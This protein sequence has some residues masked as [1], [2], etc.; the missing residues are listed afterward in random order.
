MTTV[1]NPAD[2]S[3]A[4]E[5]ADFDATQVEEVAARLRAA[6]VDWERIGPKGRAEWMG[7]YRDWLLD[8]AQELADQLQ[9]EAGKIRSEAHIE[10]ALALQVLNYYRENAARFL[11]T[12]HPGPHGLAGVVKRQWVHH[13][14]QPLIGVITPWNFPVALALWDA[15][16]ALMA[17][18]AVIVKPSEITPLA[19]R[20]VIEGWK[21]IGAPAI[22]E[23]VTGGAE[24][25]QAVV[26]T[27]DLIQFTGSTRTGRRIAEQAARRLIP[28]EL[29]LGGKDAAVVL[30]DA[31]VDQAVNA[32][33]WGALFNSGQTCVSVERVYV[34]APVYD[35]FLAKLVAKVGELRDA[36]QGDIGAMATEAQ[37]NLVADQVAD[38]E[39]KGARIL[40]GGKQVGQPGLYF[41]PTVLSQVDHTMTCMTE[42]TFGPL[43]PVMRVSDVDDAVARVNDSRYGLSAAIFSGSARRAR[44][45]AQRLEVGAVNVND[46]ILNLLAFS[47]P[48]GGWKESGIGSR[49]GGA[50][51]ILKYCRKQAIVDNLLPAPLPLMR[52]PYQWLQIDLLPR[53][54]RTLGARGILRRL[55]AFR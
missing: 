30:A 12:E 23:C 46:V 11:R 2:G 21:E 41:Q 16:P 54:Y 45:L 5:V 9:Q 19:T 3:V 20:F 31:N 17:G 15:L 38:A 48:H 7:R 22:F 24:S 49:S 42:E 32:I 55:R 6:Q 40:C 29:E 44:K 4:A 34:E 47:V 33:T 28:C 8:H 26:D 43:I 37:L 1:Y 50:H 27:V 52:M 18:C 14:P 13:R 10:L 39:A 25:G 35:E 53:L 51:G 36:G